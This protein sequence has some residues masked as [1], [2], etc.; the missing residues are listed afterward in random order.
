MPCTL[1]RRVSQDGALCS[2]PRPAPR[3]ARTA[4]LT[5]AH[6]PARGGRAPRSGARRA[7]LGQSPGRPP[8]R[9]RRQRRQRRTSW[10]GFE[11]DRLR[12]SVP[13]EPDEPGLAHEQFSAQTQKKR[14]AERAA[15]AARRNAWMAPA[16][17]GRHVVC[18]VRHMD[19]KRGRLFHASAP[20]ADAREGLQG[21]LVDERVGRNSAR[22]RG[23]SRGAHGH[24]R[25]VQQE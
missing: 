20:A 18:A 13:H 1:G 3:R 12:L 11:R 8:Q 10:R 2:R 15:L 23:Q 22:A 16:R 17:R 24:G 7:P 25:M 21:V 19:R 5:P 4:L 14:K 9:P 6:K